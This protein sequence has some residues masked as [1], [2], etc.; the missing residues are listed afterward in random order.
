[1]NDAGGDASVGFNKGQHP[2]NVKSGI[3]PDFLIGVLKQ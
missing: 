1:M 3:L 2:P